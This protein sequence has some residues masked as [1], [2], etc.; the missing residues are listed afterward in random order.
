MEVCMHFNVKEEIIALTPQWKGERF[1]DGRP[2]VADK[3][4][5]ALRNLTLEE[6]WKPIFVKGYES[7]FE[8]RLKTLHDDGRKLIGRA[9]TATFAPTRPPTFTKPCLPSAWKRE[10]R[11]TIISG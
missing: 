4:L 8:G 1:E 10:E 9:V 3:Y 5:K 11:E 6:V 7:Q 2:K